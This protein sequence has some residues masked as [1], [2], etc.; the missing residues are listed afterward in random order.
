MKVFGTHDEKTLAQMREVADGAVHSALMADGHYGYGMPIGGVAAYRNQV[1]PTGVGFD[2][3]CG[4]CAVK[5]DDTANLGPMRYWSHLGREI[6]NTFAFGVG[7][8]NEHPNAPTDH[9]L[10]DSSIWDVIP[11][12]VTKPNGKQWG[13]EALRQRARTQLG[14]IGSGNHY[15]DIFAGDDGHV[16]IGVHFGS[17]GMGHAIA[18][19][20]MAAAMGGTWGDPAKESH[21]LLDLDTETGAQ[22]WAL[23][24]LAGAY[25]YA[26]REWVCETVA[27]M[28][29]GEIVDTVHNNHN[30][31][32]KEDHFGE[33]LVVVR[34]GATPAMPGM[35][36]FV[37]GSMGDEAVIL[38]GALRDDM[39]GAQRGSLY[40]TVHGAGRVM[41]R[42][43]ATGCNRRGKQIRD[44]RI[45]RVEM[46]QW[47]DDRGVL[48][49]GADLD[50]SPGAYRRL[51]DVLAEQGDTVE[52]ETILTPLVVVMA[53]GENELNPFLKEAK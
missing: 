48:V 41:S 4:N 19:W 45:D 11:R 2:I 5:L 40:S 53:S 26:G 42:T 49:F 23:M 3:A 28:I 37:G 51:P 25:A 13:M 27:E 15:V 36:G 12:C 16:W 22:Y 8:A 31:A 17:R 20:G 9:R 52:V 43:D 47:I 46:Q 38:H 18:T 14:S 32:W 44:P 35:R 29:G 33:D 24:C 1:S 6:Q 34:K 21:E 39:D 7:R 50:E 30:F 10:F